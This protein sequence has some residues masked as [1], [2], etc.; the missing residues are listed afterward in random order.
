M[1]YR[2]FKQTVRGMLGIIGELSNEEWEYMGNLWMARMGEEIKDIRKW[3]EE[4]MMSY[5]ERLVGMEAM[6]VMMFLRVMREVKESEGKGVSDSVNGSDYC[7]DLRA[8][9]VGRME[10]VSKKVAHQYI[11]EKKVNQVKEYY[12]TIPIWEAGFVQLKPE[13]E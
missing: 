6:R 7:I 11:F 10:E 8:R 3:G 13:G 2:V 9:N 1:E 4:E 12:K 5:D